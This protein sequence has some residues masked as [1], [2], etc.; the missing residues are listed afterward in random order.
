MKSKHSRPFM[1]GYGIVGEKEGAGLLPWDFVAERMAAA[2]NYW[3]ST[4][5]TAGP[6]AAPVWGLW[7][8]GALY[9]STGVDS[10]KGRNLAASPQI[11]AHLES[12][13]EVVIFEGRVEEVKDSTVLRSLDKDYKKK[14]GML[15][16]GPGQIFKLVASKVFAWR[17]KDFPQSATR[18]SF[19]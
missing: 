9:F 3:V 13:D 16:Q 14:Y 11:S 8:A 5:G 19:E 7:H 2:Q 6:H 12:G 15:M 17:E 1:P 4:A 18:W 10:R